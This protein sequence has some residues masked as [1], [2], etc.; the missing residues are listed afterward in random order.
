ML[1]GST[2]KETLLMW[3]RGLG[4]Q[5]E[6]PPHA[7]TCTALATKNTHHLRF[8]VY[9]LGFRVKSRCQELRGPEYNH[10]YP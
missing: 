9:R 5:V 4:V 2:T 3:L 1:L 6:A 8:R 7:S 10:Y